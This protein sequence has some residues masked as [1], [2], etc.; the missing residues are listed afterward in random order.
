MKVFVTNNNQE[1][2]DKLG[3]MDIPD[4]EIVGDANAAKLVLTEEKQQRLLSKPDGQ[5]SA[6]ELIN[7]F[8]EENASDFF[9]LN[10]MGVKPMNINLDV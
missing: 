6:G 3:K 1:V 5:E 7:I 8:L 2:I 4:L 10:P 9:K